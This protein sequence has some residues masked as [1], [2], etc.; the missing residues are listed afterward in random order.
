MRELAQRLYA[1]YRSAMAN[2]NVTVPTWDYMLLEEQMAWTVV[3]HQADAMGAK[4]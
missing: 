3:A 4:S 2:Q 1:S